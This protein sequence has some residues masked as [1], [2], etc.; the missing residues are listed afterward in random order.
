MGLTDDHDDQSSTDQ[1]PSEWF[2]KSPTPAA[3]LQILRERCIIGVQSLEQATLSVD[4]GRVQV[5]PGARGELWRR[6]G[7][8]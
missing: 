2:R 6:S 4:I 1:Q 3:P 5:D 7:G 8:F